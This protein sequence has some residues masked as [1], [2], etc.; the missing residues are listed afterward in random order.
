[1]GQKLVQLTMPG[2]IPPDVYQGTELW[3]DSL[4]DPDNRRPVDFAARRELL[5][6]T[7]APWV[8]ETGKAKFWVVR[9]ALTLRRERP[10][11]FASYTPVR[12]TGEAAQHFL[13]FDRG[14]AIT[15]VT[16]LPY[17]LG[18]RGDCGGAG[19]WGRHHRGVGRHLARRTHRHRAQ[20]HR[21]GLPAVRAAPP[22]CPAGPAGL[23]ERKSPV[24]APPC[25]DP[26]RPLA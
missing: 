18:T 9:Q 22:R 12:A 15:A 6:L 5:T 7:D 4:V 1:M 19:C 26:D 11:L 20:W 13:G 8:E 21:R 10:E 23:T 24:S 16:R 25:T 2:G 17:T 14:G 3:E